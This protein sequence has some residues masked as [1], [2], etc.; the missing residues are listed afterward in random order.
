M[1]PLRFL[2]EELVTENRQTPNRSMTR[3]GMMSTMMW[4][5]TTSWVIPLTCTRV[6]PCLMLEI[7]WK[8]FY[9][10]NVRT[11]LSIALLVIS[12]TK[13]H[14]M[15]SGVHFKLKPFTVHSAKSHTC[16]VILFC[17]FSHW[18][19]V[20]PQTNIKGGQQF[21]ASQWAVAQTET[22]Y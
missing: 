22:A 21:W 6:C 18:N 4:W 7:G 13:S 8:P 9:C 10:L 20:S 1:Q 12:P 5:C 15:S 17:G 14:Q 3:E 16:D 2:T 11:Q 19:K